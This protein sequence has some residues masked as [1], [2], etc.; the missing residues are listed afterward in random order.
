MSKDRHIKASIRNAGT[1]GMG[2]LENNQKKRARIEGSAGE[3]G[4]KN[5]VRGDVSSAN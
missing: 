2:D 5:R 4:S 1:L 3:G